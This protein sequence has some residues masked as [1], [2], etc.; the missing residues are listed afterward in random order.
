MVN[1]KKIPEFKRWLSQSYPR[2]GESWRHPRG[3]HSKIHIKEKSKFKLPHPSYGAPKALRFLHPSGFREIL[4][5]N[6]KELES[7]N[8]KLEAAKIANAVGA[9]KRVDIVKKAGEMKVK[10]LNP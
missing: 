1:D 10:V 3:K 2:L 4:V 8:P 6:L 7:I 5:H 9:K